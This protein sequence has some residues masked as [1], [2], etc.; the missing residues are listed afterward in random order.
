MTTLTVEQTREKLNRKMA[1][2]GEKMAAGGYLNPT[3][4]L[5]YYRTL[6]TIRD[7]ETALRRLS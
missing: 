4:T 6:S 5:E 2:I 3:I 7:F 1:A